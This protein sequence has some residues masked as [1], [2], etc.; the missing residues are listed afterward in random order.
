M[1]GQALPHLLR[2]RVQQQQPVALRANDHML[3]VQP[4]LQMQHTNVLRL[5][6]HGQGLVWQP[7]MQTQSG[8][9]LLL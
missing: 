9:L 4:L 1:E 7:E 2:G 6:W 8:V 5:A 3:C